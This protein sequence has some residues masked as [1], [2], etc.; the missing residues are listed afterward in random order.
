[1]G[2]G[3]TV[4][5]VALIASLTFVFA[6]PSLAG[7]GHLPLPDARL[8]QKTAP[9][10]LLSRPDVR[11]DLGLTPAQAQSAETAITKLYVSAAALKGKTGPQA[12]K[13]RK[14]IDDDMLFWLVNNLTER[15]RA[16]LSQIDLQWEGMSALVSRP[17][18]ADTIGL[19]PEQRAK[20]K[21]AVEARDKARKVGTYSLTDEKT[22]TITALTTLT[23]DQRN[24]WKSMLGHEFA[25][26]IA[27]ARPAGPVK[28]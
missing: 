19:S 25:P 1:M 26:Q 10:L 22:L 21:L 23:E 5:Q 28:R 16:R 15:Q 13:G 6:P 20:I 3:L 27:S 9:L 18:V 11:A 8:G 12:I 17:I 14:A 4:V 2:Q 7:D 24:T